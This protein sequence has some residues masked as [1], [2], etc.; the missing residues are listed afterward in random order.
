MRVAAKFAILVAP[1]L[2]VGGFADADPVVNLGPPPGAILDMAGNPVPSYGYNE[3]TVNFTAT[4]ATTNITFAMRDDP[5]TFLLDDISVTDKTNPSGNLIVNGGFEEGPEFASAPTGW[6][7]L[8]FGP[9]SGGEAH[10]S[11]ARTG[12]YAYL[13]SARSAYDGITQS[14][15][16]QIG[17][18]Y[19]I[20]FW[21]NA[22]TDFYGTTFKQ[23]SDN[24]GSGSTGNGFDLLV[25][26]GKIPTMTAVTTG[27]PEPASATLFSAG[28]IGL[29]LRR[30]RK[31]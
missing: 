28:L 11:N 5:Q 24:G 2:L 25:Y 16:T 17:D 12:S 20:D 30:R 27:A 23:V 3:Y 10:Q 29:W 15:N 22:E 18:T 6:T 26:A 4:A 19:V 8:T 14:I 1:C 21:F 31:G 9:T 7:Y 13:D